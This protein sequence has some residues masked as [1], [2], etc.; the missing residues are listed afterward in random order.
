PAMALTGSRQWTRLRRTLLRKS[1]ITVLLASGSVI[2]LYNAVKL[3]PVSKKQFAAHDLQGRQALAHGYP[4]INW[5]V[6]VCGV[7]CTM[8][9]T[10]A[11]DRAHLGEENND[12]GFQDNGGKASMATRI[13]LATQYCRRKT[14]LHSNDTDIQ[15]VPRN[16]K[17]CKLYSPSRSTKFCPIAKIASTFWVRLYKVLE[18]QSNVSVLDSPFSVPLAKADS[19]RCVNASRKPFTAGKIIR[20]TF[21]R[22]P[23]SRV[24]S[25]YVD[26]LLSPNPYLWG[27]W[28]KAA[29]RL[30]GVPADAVHCGERVTFRQFLRLINDR[31]YRHDYHVIPM[32]AQ[33][34]PCREEFDFIGKM[35]TFP[36]DLEY[37]MSLLGTTFKPE[38]KMSQEAKE[39]AIY[40]SIQGPFSWKSS[41]VKCVSTDEMGKRIWRKLQIRGL[42]SSSIDYPFGLQ[43]LTNMTTEEYLAVAV[44]A[45]KHSTDKLALTRQKRQALV[46]AFRTVA[47]SDILRYQ[48]IFQDDFEAFGY[49]THPAFVFDRTGEFLDTD[50]FNFNAPWE[51][52]E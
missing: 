37:F 32:A 15:P 49:D 18:K 22:E 13:A 24:F 23:F 5:Y 19:Q 6:F 48:K 12:P 34:D 11:Y 27:G 39:D 28:G 8:A 25:A 43:D 14:T 42:I 45:S 17:N 2:L 9:N 36:A 7:A 30:G 47:M 26:K 20:G 21:V 10:L 16:V 35:E 29:M 31:L 52:P 51:I 3:S 44:N 41:I 4:E 50:A 1:V 46:E 33:C 40:D 38:V